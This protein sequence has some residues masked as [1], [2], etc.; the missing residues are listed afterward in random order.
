MTQNEAMPLVN[1]KLTLAYL[2]EQPIIHTE[3][4]IGNISKIKKMR[5]IYKGQPKSVPALSGNS[6][7]GQLRDILADQLCASLSNQ[8]RQK[9]K[10][11]NNDVY[12]ILYSG[13]ALGEKRTS[14]QLIHSFSENLPSMRLMGAAFGNV[15]LPSKLAATHIIPCAEETHQVLQRMY[16]NLETG[17]IPPVSE[18]PNANNLVFN[19]GP[20]TRKDDHRDLTRQRFAKPETVEPA[21][22]AENEERQGSQM[23][24]YVEC[25]PSGTWLLQQLYSKLPLDQLEL[26][27]LFDGL[28]AFLETPSLGG[29]SAAGYGQVQVKIQG[30]VGSE[31][32]NWPK[33]WP[34][35]VKKAVEA[36][37][38][39]LIA[40][41]DALLNTLTVTR[42]NS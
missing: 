22:G 10:F 41:Q 21:T 16:E 5:V 39:Y 33:E 13:G 18:W 30:F 20:L 24:Y 1:V 40:K 27:C 31:A 37:R 8:G 36:Y 35:S 34:E 11:S 26:G 32:I 17:L 15:M 42:E 6:F 9:L 2:A 19:D 29:R 4:T 3:E 23:I 28:S 7:R 14:A 12:G 25:I 38:N